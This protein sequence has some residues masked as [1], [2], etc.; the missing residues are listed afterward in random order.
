M[1]FLVIC[2]PVI[3]FLLNKYTDDL[4][5]NEESLNLIRKFNAQE[6]LVPEEC[7]K[8]ID[9]LFNFE[10]YLISNKLD[11][12]IDPLRRLIGDGRKWTGLLNILINQ[13]DE[14]FLYLY[15]P[16]SLK[17]FDD[18]FRETFAYGYSDVRIIAPLI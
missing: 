9:I 3:K 12:R 1:K 5:P 15:E 16:S 18:Q 7:L 11:Y 13:E 6:I 17:N 8:F 14:V 10:N 2:S 4:S